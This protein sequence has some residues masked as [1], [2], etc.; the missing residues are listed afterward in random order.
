MTS[1]HSI[2][3]KLTCLVAA[4]VSLR[5]DVLEIGNRRELFVDHYLIERMGGARVEILESDGRAI[6][7]FTRA[8]AVELIGDD[9]ER[10]VA[11]K[12]GAELA[13]LAGRP[14]RLRFVMKDADVYSLQFR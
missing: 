3:F 6:P 7:D 1:R 9:L 2:A 8:D 13:P 12:Q 5:A 4:T 14:I 11:W 10:V